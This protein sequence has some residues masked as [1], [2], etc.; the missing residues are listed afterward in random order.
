MQE[1]RVWSLGWKDPACWRAAKPMCHNYR[2]CALEPAWEAQVLSP[3]ATATKT[4]SPRAHAP[5]PETP[6]PREAWAPQLEIKPQLLQLEKSLGS[7]RNPALPKIYKIKIFL[8]SLFQDC[9]DGSVLETPW[10]QIMTLIIKK[11][12]T[13]RGEALDLIQHLILIIWSFLQQAFFQYQPCAKNFSS[14]WIQEW[15]KWA[16]LPAL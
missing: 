5:Q 15:I 1:T 3:C 12:K 10:V 13:Y 7:N 16:E 6:L 2:A 11:E 14:H 4:P 8:K 9:K